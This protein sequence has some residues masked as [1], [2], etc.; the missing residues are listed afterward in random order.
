M[1]K[2][3]GHVIG[4]TYSDQYITTIKYHMIKFDRLMLNSDQLIFL[5][6]YIHLFT[7]FKLDIC[8]EWINADAFSCTR[9]QGPSC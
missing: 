2:S 8:L 1:K 7:D 5:V 3:P 4:W 6:Q 9:R